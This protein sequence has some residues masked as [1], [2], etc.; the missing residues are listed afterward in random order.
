MPELIVSLSTIQR[1]A[2]EAVAA[3]HCS[4]TVCPWPPESAAAQAFHDQFRAAQ[5]QSPAACENKG[6]PHVHG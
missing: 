4:H 1:H 6:I 2:Q 5:V 3:G